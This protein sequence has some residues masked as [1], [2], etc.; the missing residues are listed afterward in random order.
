MLSIRWLNKAMHMTNPQ[1]TQYF[2][3]PFQEVGPLKF[4]MSRSEVLIVL[5][6]FEREIR[7][8]TGG[9]AEM[10]EN[11]HCL[12]KRDKLHEMTFSVG[13]KLLLDGHLLLKQAGIDYLLA[14]HEHRVSDVGFTIF[15]SIG[16]G[17]TGFGKS[18]DAKVVM[19]FSKTV[20]KDYLKLLP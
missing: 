1:A 9:I 3:K 20:L 7:T 19:A 17:F 13:S 14:T 5:G 18:K 16:V 6:D 4:G 12:Y 2:L 10:R 11:I 8:F 15:P